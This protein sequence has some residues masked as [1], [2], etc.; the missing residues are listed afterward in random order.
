MMSILTLLIN[1]I[2]EVLAMALKENEMKEIQ[3]GI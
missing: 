3:T 1:M 2:L